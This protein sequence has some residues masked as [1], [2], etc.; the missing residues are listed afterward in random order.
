MKGPMTYTLDAEHNTIPLPEGV[1]HP[2]LPESRRRVA[3]ETVRGCTVSTVFLGVNHQWGDGPPILF[4]SAV[5]RGR[6]RG[7][8]GWSIAARYSTWQQAEDGHKYVV[9]MIKRGD[10]LHDGI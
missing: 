4:E 5:Y 2:M 10:P 3:L 1:A 9:E 6:G 8:K 7:Q